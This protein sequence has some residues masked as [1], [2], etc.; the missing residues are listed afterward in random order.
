M[1]HSASWKTATVSLCLPLVV[2]SLKKTLFWIY[3]L[4]CMQQYLTYLI[5]GSGIHCRPGNL[6]LPEPPRKGSGRFWHIAKHSWPKNQWKETMECFH[7]DS[8]GPNKFILKPKMP[9]LDLKCCF[10]YT[11]A[12]E[13]AAPIIAH[14]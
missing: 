9:G 5:L 13:N 11:W 7:E 14:Y 1:F 6:Y 12:R 8:M 2:L 3:Y 4:C 10:K